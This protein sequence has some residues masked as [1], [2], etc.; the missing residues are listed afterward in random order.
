MVGVAATNPSLAWR[1]QAERDERQGLVEYAPILALTS[2]AANA[3]MGALVSAIN[4][5]FAE[6]GSTLL[7]YT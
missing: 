4:M 7:L 5:V 3:G 2:L 6:P 1:S